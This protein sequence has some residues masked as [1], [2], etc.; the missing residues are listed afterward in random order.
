MSTDNSIIRSV[1]ESSAS[2]Y[3]RSQ[4]EDSIIGNKAIVGDS[5]RVIS[6]NIGDFVRIDR[7]NL[8][9]HSKIGRYSY[10]GPFDLIFK[11][12]IG[13]FTSISYG[14]TIG[15]PEHDYTI[16]TTH[17]FLYDSRYEIFSKEEVM[18]S[19]KF[20]SPIEI[21]SDVWIGC[22]AT[23][24]R[25]CHIRHGAVVGA[26]SLVK[27][28][29][30]PYAIVAGCPAKLIKFRFPEK[31]IQELLDLGWWNWSVEKIRANSYLFI[32]EHPINLCR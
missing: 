31:K 27:V 25:G 12:L 7:N 2:L 9:Y 1:V 20:E 29:V 22:N 30:P 11:V 21:G 14:V 19:H 3:F 5:S 17:P 23:I 4:V 13:S 32:D 26:N 24:L 6:S 18:I 15:P 8:I 16:L 28:D 10:T